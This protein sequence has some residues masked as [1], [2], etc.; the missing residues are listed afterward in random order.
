MMELGVLDSI[1]EKLI[2]ECG[3]LG[4][5]DFEWQAADGAMSKARFEGIS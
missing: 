4:G 3:E 5:A 1:W 2:E